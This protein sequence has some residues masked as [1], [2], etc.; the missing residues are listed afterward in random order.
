MSPV[1]AP[2]IDVA[3]VAVAAHPEILTW[4]AGWVAATLG[5]WLRAVLPPAEDGVERAM[6]EA[7][8]CVM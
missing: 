7:G 2:G 1:F 3:A 5:F 8:C 6:L 4:A